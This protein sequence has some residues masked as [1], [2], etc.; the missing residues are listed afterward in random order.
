[1]FKRRKKTIE[2]AK[3]HEDSPAVKMPKAGQEHS[4]L[5]VE[6]RIQLK[7][8]VGFVLSENPKLTDILIEGPTLR[9]AMAD[10][11]VR[12][13]VTSTPDAAR[14]SGVIVEVLERAHAKL[15]GSFARLQGQPVL[16]AEN[17]APPVRLLDLQGKNPG[18]GELVVAQITEWPTM[19]RSAGGVVVEV[20]GPRSAPGVELKGLIHKYAPSAGRACP[21]NVTLCGQECWPE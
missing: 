17:D 11:R 20:L 9:L 12:A 13:R 10:D 5:L 7:G 2:P 21:W 8:R 3:N 14:R 1:M 15:V 6:G 18:D 4:S 19:E 16:I